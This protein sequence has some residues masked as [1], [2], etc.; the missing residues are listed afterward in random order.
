M[1]TDKQRLA[2]FPLRWR[3]VPPHASDFPVEQLVPLEP[4]SARELHRSLEALCD[5]L[6]LACG[7]VREIERFDLRREDAVSEW[8]WSRPVQPES[9]L[10]SWDADTAVA[11][12]WEL[13][14]SR[15]DDLWYPASDDLTVVDPDRSFVLLLAHDE[16]ALFGVVASAA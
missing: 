13:F 15:W 8:L 7:R 12:P 5:G 6:L 14:V 10:L 9:V 2:S 16:T 11:L 1:S 3:F 4:S